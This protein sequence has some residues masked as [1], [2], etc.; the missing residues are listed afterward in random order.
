M[1]SDIDFGDLDSLNLK[2]EEFVSG[3]RRINSN[4][5]IFGFECFTKYFFCGDVLN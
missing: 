3:I 2:Y 4:S 1:K 5:K